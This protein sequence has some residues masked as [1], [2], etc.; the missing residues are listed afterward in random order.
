M[1]QISGETVST[2]GDFCEWTRGGVKELLGDLVV[3]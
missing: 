3:I 1:S 2:G